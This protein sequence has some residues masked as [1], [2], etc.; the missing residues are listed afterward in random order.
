MILDLFRLDGKVAILTGA[1]RGI[2]AASAIA[3][4]ECGA[5]VVIASRTQADLDE[6]AAKVAKTGQRAVTVAGDLADLDVM[7]SLVT[8]ARGIRPPRRG[9]E[10]R[11]GRDPTSVL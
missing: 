10:Q 7:R 2:G 8:R 1:G 6:V 11:R 5:N 3:L 9:G 4:A